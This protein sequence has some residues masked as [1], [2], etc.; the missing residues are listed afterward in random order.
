MTLFFYS[1]LWFFKIKLFPRHFVNNLNDAIVSVYNQLNRFG[2]TDCTYL[3]LR[4]YIHDY[5]NKRIIILDIISGLKNLL[6]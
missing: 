6:N 3:T 4:N 1:Q 2:Q 5:A